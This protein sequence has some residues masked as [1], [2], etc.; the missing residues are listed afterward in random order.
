MQWRFRTGRKASGGKYHKGCKKT[1]AQRGRDF[2]PAS[3][4]K[5]K[6]IQKRTRGGNT[7]QIAVRVETA[8]VVVDGKIEKL[9]I[10]QVKKNDANPQFIRS[11][12]VTKGCLI[13]TE[14][15]FARVTSRPGQNGSVDAVLVEAKK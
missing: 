4:G 1:R 3:L 15:G 7:K 11:N 2:I 13:E 14:K 5:T 10:I 9:K 8:N 6:I 12:I